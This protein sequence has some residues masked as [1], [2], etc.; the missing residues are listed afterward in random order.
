M[1][2]LVVFQTVLGCDISDLLLEGHEPTSQE[3]HRT[4]IPIPEQT[5]LT[6]DHQDGATEL[7]TAVVADRTVI[8]KVSSVPSV[9][10]I[11]DRFRH[12]LLYGRKKDAL[13]WASKHHLWGHALFLASKMDNRT[14][15][16]IMTRY[17]SC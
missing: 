11:T 1:Y 4:G 15:A 2:D 10:E 12:L 17:A 16:N 5:A 7:T 13:E 8:N 6:H 14:H 9:N 3:Y